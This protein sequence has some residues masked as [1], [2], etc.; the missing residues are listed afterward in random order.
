MS[1]SATASK[2]GA[3]AT[4]VSSNSDEDK[5]DDPKPEGQRLSNKIIAVIVGVSVFVVLAAFAAALTMWCRKRRAK[6]TPPPLDISQPLPGSGRQFASGDELSQEKGGDQTF[7]AAYSSPAST[8]GSL[9]RS[10]L[11]V[12]PTQHPRSSYSSEL[13]REARRYEDMPPR[14]QPRMMI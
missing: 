8:A 2:S 9:A 11:A 4:N 6:N 5:D 14:A 1:S 13:D 7:P 12:D 3:A 10:Q